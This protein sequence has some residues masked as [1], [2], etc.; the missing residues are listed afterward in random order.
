[1]QAIFRHL[2]FDGW[3]LGDLVLSGLRVFAVEGLT[4]S[5]AGGRLHRNG[6]LD[7][8]RRHQGP[9]LA[10]VTWLPAPLATG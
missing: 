1:V 8:L 6:L 3:Y 7:L 10:G 4:T 9:L 2:G 5:A